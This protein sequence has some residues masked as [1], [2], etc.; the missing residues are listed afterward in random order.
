MVANFSVKEFSLPIA[1]AILLALVYFNSVF[2]FISGFVVNRFLLIN[3]TL[4]GAVFMTALNPCATLR[5]S[6]RLLP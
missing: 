2:T 6:L 3:V 5:L 4:S 1:G